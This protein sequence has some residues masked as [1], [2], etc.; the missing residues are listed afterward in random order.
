M[1]G[2]KPDAFMWA[3]HAERFAGGGDAFACPRARWSRTPTA[4]PRSAPAASRVSHC[5]VERR[6]RGA[7]GGKLLIPQ[8]FD[9]VEAAR[10]HGRVDAEEQPHPAGEREAERDRPDG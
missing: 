5:R 4:A 7:A 8:G 3:I 1:A 2:G 10:P 6:G 9:R